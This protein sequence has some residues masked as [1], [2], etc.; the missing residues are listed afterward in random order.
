M[1]TQLQADQTVLTHV[2]LQQPPLADQKQD[3]NK[4]PDIKA[5]ILITSNKQIRTNRLRLS[6]L[7]KEDQNRVEKIDPVQKINE[8]RAAAI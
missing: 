7:P 5:D 2:A 8:Q 6:W 3:D 1:I 4:E